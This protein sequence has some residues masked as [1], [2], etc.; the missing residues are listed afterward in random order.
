MR[1]RVILCVLLSASFGFGPC[2]GGAPDGAPDKSKPQ[3]SPPKSAGSDDDFEPAPLDS[4][5][6]GELTGS[7]PEGGTW[8]LQVHNCGNPHI[9]GPWTGTMTFSVA[10][11][12][13]SMKAESVDW[14]TA[15]VGDDAG[16]PTPLTVKAKV[17]AS[18]PGGVKMKMDTSTQIEAWT[19]GTKFYVFREK[20]ATGDLKATAPGVQLSWFGGGSADKL[21]KIPLTPNACDG[22]RPKKPL[23]P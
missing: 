22:K 14:P 18:A 7:T 5:W 1:S 6:V 2:S 17:S 16:K 21:I 12:G 13:M 11:Q 10:A 20:T 9:K 4:N 3:P 8:K 15:T 19:E 23:T